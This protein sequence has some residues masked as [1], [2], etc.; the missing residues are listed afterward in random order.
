MIRTV[1]LKELFRNASIILETVTYACVLSHSSSASIFTS[2]LATVASNTI[3]FYHDSIFAFL[4]TCTMRDESCSV[5]ITSWTLSLCLVSSR[6]SLLLST[7]N[8][9]EL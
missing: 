3:P 9:L 6:W 8:S 5:I 2:P 1:I 4:V 7:G